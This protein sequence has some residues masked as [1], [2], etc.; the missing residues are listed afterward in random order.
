MI[1]GFNTDVTWEHTIYHVQS[2]L[3]VRERLLQTQVFVSGRCVGKIHTPWERNWDETGAQ[4][5][6][7]EQH[8]RTV[9]AARMGD[10][11]TLLGGT[12][13]T[14]E[15]PALQLD[16]TNA[17]NPYFEGIVQL[18]VIVSMEGR[19]VEG[20]ELTVALAAS[21]GEPTCTQGVTD[22]RGAAKLE[23]PASEEALADCAVVLQA[24]FGNIVTTRRYRLRRN[25]QA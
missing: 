7:R 16:W 19:G 25:S 17:A 2:E 22:A 4:E 15:A 23:I 1:F 8:G 14:E 3:R 9:A 10:V 21:G 12:E 13:Q 11:E 5:R 20:A 18:R 24:S 6:L